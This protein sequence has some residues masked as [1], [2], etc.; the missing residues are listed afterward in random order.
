M[1]NECRRHHPGIDREDC[2]NDRDVRPIKGNGTQQ[3]FGFENGVA[4]EGYTVFLGC[5]C[6]ESVLIFPLT[7]CIIAPHP[8]YLWS[9]KYER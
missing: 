5:D 4:R 9:E 8:L 3:Q 6:G 7:W 1:A 2:Q